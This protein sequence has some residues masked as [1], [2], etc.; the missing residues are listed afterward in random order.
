[1]PS[2]VQL[3]PW[4]IIEASAECTNDWMA[5][6]KSPMEEFL[7]F[8][9]GNMRK[10]R[11]YNPFL[12]NCSYYGVG[13][14]WADNFLMK[15]GPLINGRASEPLV[16][17][18]PEKQKEVLEQS[19]PEFNMNFLGHVEGDVYGV[20][21]RILSKIDKFEGN[22]NTVNREQ[23]YVS[24]CHSLQGGKSAKCFMYVADFYAYDDWSA[25]YGSLMSCQSNVPV[26]GGKRL[27]YHTS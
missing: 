3:E 9:T 6:K 21:L 26:A 19:Y 10:N 17:E 8:V 5:L 18:F 7:V 14:S 24:F 11:R 16:F 2:N 15:R 12:S 13:K 1:M 20:P 22:G 23:R 25:S 27:Y 4:D